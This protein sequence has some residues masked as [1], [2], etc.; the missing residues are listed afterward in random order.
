MPE[1]SCFSLTVDCV[2]WEKVYVMTVLG[3]WWGSE[4]LWVS[5]VV[6][7]VRG[8]WACVLPL[9]MRVSHVT[10]DSSRAFPV[11][12]LSSSPQMDQPAPPPPTH[13]QWQGLPAGWLKGPCVA[14]E[15]NLG[16]EHRNSL[17][18]SRVRPG[19]PRLPRKNLDISGLA[20]QSWWRQQSQSGFLFSSAFCDQI[21]GY[22]KLP[23]RPRVSGSNMVWTPLG[24]RVGELT[25]GRALDGKVP[26]PHVVLQEGASETGQG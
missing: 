4:D 19:F 20:T 1:R 22:R 2:L 10:S 3:D 21:Q 9:C 15:L 7:L 24:S 26:P 8:S 14:L 23:S 16:A 17:T 18:W 6:W 5:A 11:S 25:R 12:C 13:E